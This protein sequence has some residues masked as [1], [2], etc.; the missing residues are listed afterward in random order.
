M[1][2]PIGSLFVLTGVFATPLQAHHSV[3]GVFD[4]SKT[5]KLSGTVSRVDWINPHTFIYVD[6]KDDTGAVTTWKLESLPV[7]MM[8]KAGITSQLIVSGGQPVKVEANPARAGTA[9]LGFVLKLTYED[10]RSYQFG[11]TPDDKP[12][13]VP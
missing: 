2:L 11:R 4:V 9:N 8:R 1:R 3:S 12:T 10:G 7:A 13:A 5:V 6:V